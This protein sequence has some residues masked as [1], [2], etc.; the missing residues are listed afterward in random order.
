MNIGESVLPVLAGVL[1]PG[2]AA[3]QPGQ[4]Q[5]LNIIHIMSD[6]HSYQ[7]I[8]AYGGPLSD[9]APTPNIDRLAAQGMLFTRAYVENSISS[10]SRATLLTGKYSH[11]HGKTI[12]RARCP[13]DSSQL[14]FPILLQ[15]AGYQTA[16]FGKWHL[17]TDPYGFDDWKILDGQGTY[18]S[19]DF[20]GRGDEGF[21]TQ[22]GYVADIITDYAID[23]L[24]HR[25]TERPFC[26]LVH[27]KSV[28]RNWF[29]EPKYFNLYDDVTFPEPATFLDDYS[30]R[31][32][33]AR[34]QQM[35][36]AKDMSL[37]TDNKVWQL[38]PGNPR[39]K[40]DF[41]KE[42]DRMSPQERQMFIEAYGD[43]NE[44]FL[45]ANLTGTELTRWKYQRYIHDY[46]RCVKSLDDEIG[47]LLDYLEEQGLM[48]D[49]I[50]VYTSDQGFYMGEHNWF[51]KRFMYEESF[52][53]PLIIC[54]PGRI[55]PGS[56]CDALVQ[57]IDFAPTYLTAAGLEVPEEMCGEPLQPLFRSGKE[58]GKWRKDLYYHYWDY[59]AVH[60]VRRHD[61]VATKRYKL[62]HFKD[63]GGGNRKKDAPIDQWEFYDLRKDP[64]EINNQYGNPKYRRAIARLSKRLEEYRSTLQIHQAES[65]F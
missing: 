1:L 62:I 63:D 7:T 60:N 18:Y 39:K 30:T 25:D 3:A 29:P 6:D 17:E 12:L 59:P 33:A 24:E 42:F 38:L 50:I 28:H 47:R 52:R 55:R 37:S 11:Q 65:T 2:I 61:G 45:K 49:T 46:V 64:S 26:L 51:D 57:N 5:R 40:D 9:L 15:E 48:D 58:P 21:T 8:S 35:T 23:W 16:V 20:R 10:P 43:G 4:P 41:H 27:H 31:C 56:V 34:Q 32:D 22:E 36:I 19:P 54:C 13:Y 14:S 44:E 53:T